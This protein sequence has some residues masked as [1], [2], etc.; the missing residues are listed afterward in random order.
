LDVRKRRLSIA[1]AGLAAVALAWLAPPGRAP[2][3][4]LPVDKVPATAS[5]PR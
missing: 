1:A 4:A 2:E 3:V 5:A